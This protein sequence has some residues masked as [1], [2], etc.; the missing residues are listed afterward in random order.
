MLA[1]GGSKK[2]QL[3]P[4]AGMPQAAARLM[5]CWPQIMSKLLHVA[6]QAYMSRERLAAAKKLQLILVAG[7]GSDHIDLEAAAAA[8]LTVAECTGA[9]FHWR[10]L[11]RVRRAWRHWR[12][13]WGKAGTPAGKSFGVMSALA[14]GQALLPEC[15]A[16]C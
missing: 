12:S 13:A 15:E 9:R 4:V 7:V 8:G 11:T 1:P 14:K 10:S 6:A 2:L 16:T 5:Q 3:L